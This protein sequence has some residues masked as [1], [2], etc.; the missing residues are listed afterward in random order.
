VPALVAALTHVGPRGTQTQQSLEFGVLVA[1][2]GVQIDVQPDLARR[3]IGD[4][5]EHQRGRG[6]AEA[7]LRPDLD[8]AVLPGE[9]PVVEDGRPE[10]GQVLGVAAVHAE[11]GEAAGHARTIGRPG[12]AGGRRP[13]GD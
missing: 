5:R 9:H 13:P 3:G 6:A 11:L 7:C 1:V 4:G 8:R 10:R 12:S 2:G